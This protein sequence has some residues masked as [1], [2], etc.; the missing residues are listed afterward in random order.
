MVENQALGPS[1][2]RF[3][4]DASNLGLLYYLVDG[5]AAGDCRPGGPGAHH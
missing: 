3:S 1:I 5:K 4:E 2:R